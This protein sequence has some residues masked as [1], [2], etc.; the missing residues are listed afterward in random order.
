MV[1]LTVNI[2]ASS[3]SYQS[4]YICVYKWGQHQQNSKYMFL[5]EELYFPIASFTRYITQCISNLTAKIRLCIL[6][7]S[8]PVV[9]SHK[10][11]HCIEYS[12]T[13]IKSAKTNFFP[14]TYTITLILLSNC[15]L[16]GVNFQS[17]LDIPFVPV[18]QSLL[19]QQRVRAIKL[20]I[21]I[22]IS[23]CW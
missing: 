19:G 15:C 7:P 3:S 20:L 17:S 9:S 5:F 10:G 11:G 18:S 22:K 23:D 1:D 16:H 13:V 4:T 14:G 6:S 21:R 2:V 12:Q 8:F